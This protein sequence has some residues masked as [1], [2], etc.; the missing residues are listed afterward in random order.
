MRDDVRKARLFLCLLSLCAQPSRGES[1]QHLIPP[2]VPATQRQLL[3]SATH[4]AVYHTL[5]IP[6]F[7]LSSIPEIHRDQGARHRSPTS[8][9]ISSPSRF[10]SSQAICWPY[11]KPTY[12]SNVPFH[13]LGNASLQ[14]H[15]IPSVLGLALFYSGLFSLCPPPS[16]LQFRSSRSRNT[17]TTMFGRKK[18]P[19]PAG[20]RTGDH[21]GSDRTLTNESA[22]ASPAQIKRATRTRFI[23]ALIAALL[24]LISVIFLILVEVGNIGDRAVSRDTYFIQIDLS[25]IVP[26]SVPNAMLINSIAQTLGL[27]DYYRVGLWNYCAGNIGTGILNCSKPQTMWWFNPVEIIQSQLLAGASSMSTLYQLQLH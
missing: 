24:L 14:R 6:V 25:N 21:P 3:P 13:P 22:H 20:D 18:A 9:S 7:I 5:V 1:Y 17:T 4:A 15:C 2:R 8:R 26:V 27:N 12:Y 19:D 10:S 16:A 23:W 11:T